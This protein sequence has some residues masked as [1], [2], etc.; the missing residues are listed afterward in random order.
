[1]VNLLAVIWSIDCAERCTLDRTFG[2]NNE[3]EAAS[4]KLMKLIA[5]ISSPHEMCLSICILFGYACEYRTIG[6]HISTAIFGNER[7][8]EE[9]EKQ[10]VYIEHK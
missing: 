8:F 1:M 4:L 5:S 9:N 7:I 3:K 2:I 10:C 6:L